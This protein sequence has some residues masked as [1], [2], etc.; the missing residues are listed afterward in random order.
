MAEFIDTESGDYFCVEWLRKMGL[1]AHAFVTPSAVVIRSRDDNQ[2]A[3]HARGH[4]LDSLG[5]EFLVP[6]LH[7][8]ATFLQAINGDYLNSHELA[9]GVEVVRGWV[10]DHTIEAIRQHSQLSPDR[11]ADPGKGFPWTKFLNDVKGV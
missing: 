7:T 2:G 6:G 1:S 11:K 3:W 5:I 9:A 10:A 8:Y 4:N